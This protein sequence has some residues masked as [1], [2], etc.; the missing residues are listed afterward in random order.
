MPDSF[1]YYLLCHAPQQYESTRS[2]RGVFLS[3]HW[4]QT[5][6]HEPSPYL[7][8]KNN[9]LIF[10]FVKTK[11]DRKAGYVI[12][13]W[14]WEMLKNNL[15]KTFLWEDEILET[16][17]H[18]AGL[19]HRD[20]RGWMKWQKWTFLAYGPVVDVCNTSGSVK[21]SNSLSRL[22]LRFSTKILCRELVHTVPHSRIE[23]LHG[24]IPWKIWTPTSRVSE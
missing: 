4:K 10:G 18:P 13:M 8:H 15:V 1:I 5:V 21:Q 16:Y 22:T 2:V 7:I 9:L 17:G 11:M 3:V 24:L 12:H 20:K 19:N 14:K 6:V 23:L